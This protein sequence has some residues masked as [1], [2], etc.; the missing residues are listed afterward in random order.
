MV[1]A[2]FAVLLNE[3]RIGD[4]EIRGQT[5]EFAFNETYLADPGRA[6]LGLR[7]EEDLGRSHM[8]FRRLPGWFSNLLPEGRFRRFLL[9][10]NETVDSADPMKVETRLLAALGADLPG[11]VQCFEEHDDQTGS[12]SRLR[13]LVADTADRSLND[14]DNRFRFSMAGVGLKASMSESDDR[15]VLPMSGSGGRWIVKFPDSTFARLPANEFTMMTLA[16]AVG[17][18]VP[19]VRLLDR[20]QVDGIPDQF[21]GAERSAYAVER[22]DRTDGNRVHIEDLAQVRGFLPEDKYRGTFETIAAIAYRT[23]SDDELAEFVRRL[24]LFLVIGN[25]DAHLKNWSLRYGD[26]RRPILS[27]AY[28]VNSVVVYPAGLVAQ[29][30][31]LRF[32]RGRD[33]NSVGL[34][35]FYRLQQKLRSE[36]DLRSIVVDTGNQIALHLPAAMEGLRHA[37]LDPFRLGEHAEA[38]L[39]QLR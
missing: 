11:A 37:G 4:L 33:F 28:D 31:G 35:T 15:F 29:D 32:G 16:G 14:E 6:V 12:G 3:S 30:L 2:R 38:M 34:G 10:T 5:S 26:L 13:G 24:T 22:F 17:I 20:E 8:G 36:V 27:P 25:S 19:R 18:R 21:W 7:F 1:D 39:A 23:R 9:G